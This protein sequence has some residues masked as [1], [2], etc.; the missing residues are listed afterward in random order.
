MEAR[1]EESEEL[2]DLVELGNTA[3]THFQKEES[4]LLA[5]GLQD[6]ST[7]ER[8]GKIKKL[9]RRA[10]RLY[11]N[12]QYAEAM[13]VYAAVCKSDKETIEALEGA[14]F[15]AFHLDR[16]EVAQRCFTRIS[17]RLAAL[18]FETVHGL[19]LVPVTGGSFLMGATEEEIDL[20]C[21]LELDLVEKKRKDTE[22][23]GKTLAINPDWDPGNRSDLELQLFRHPV[24]V[25]PFSVAST[26]VSNDLFKEFD[27][28]FAPPMKPLSARSARL[29][30]Q[31]G[32][33]R[34]LPLVLRKGR[35]TV[36]PADRGRMGI[37]GQGGWHSERNARRAA[38]SGHDGGRISVV[39]RQVRARVLH[40]GPWH[41]SLR[42]R[43]GRGIRSAWWVVQVLRRQLMP[44]PLGE[45]AFHAVRSG[46]RCR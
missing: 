46:H 13:K 1:Q 6:L 44:V 10:A 7:T 15:C 5:R 24:T 21:Q 33:P 28:D 29:C 31:A 14:G 39:S 12:K 11:V 27:P 16:H 4:A 8:R 37:R 38:V 40:A 18:S 20:A 3:L 45:A 17:D 9:L 34:L 26:C 25:A 43:G 41:R 30:V 23:E 2:T 19:E 35:Q 32:R 22:A 36:P 42:T